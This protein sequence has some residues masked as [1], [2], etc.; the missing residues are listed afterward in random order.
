[1]KT[2]SQVFKVTFTPAV[3]AVNPVL[4]LELDPIILVF[5]IPTT[6][7]IP[8]KVTNFSTSLTLKSVEFVD[9]SDSFMRYDSQRELITIDGEKMEERDLG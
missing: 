9:R 8:E 6:W 7:Q 1:M 2:L 4:D 5:G 3:L